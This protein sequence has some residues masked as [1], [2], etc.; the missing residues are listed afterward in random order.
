MLEESVYLKPHSVEKSED[1]HV[2]FG[3]VCPIYKMNM[4]KFFDIF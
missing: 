3:F 1:I 4:I 2:F